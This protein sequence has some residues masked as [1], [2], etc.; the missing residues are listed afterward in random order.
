MFGFLEATRKAMRSIRRFVKTTLPSRR[1][2]ENSQIDSAIMAGAHAVRDDD[3]KLEPETLTDDEPPS[4]QRQEADEADEEQDAGSQATLTASRKMLEV[5]TGGKA[6][7]PPQPPTSPSSPS[8]VLRR[9]PSNSWLPTMSSMDS[10]PPAARRKSSA[11][12]GSLRVRPR[13][14]SHPSVRALMDDYDRAE[15]A[16]D[17]ADNS[18]SETVLNTRRNAGSS[19]LVQ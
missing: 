19:S 6:S 8:R 1:P 17:S 11:S 7:K 4:Q 2:M 16:Y 14:N 18:E 15:Q 10:R 3:A 9:L 13:S 12:T 5:A